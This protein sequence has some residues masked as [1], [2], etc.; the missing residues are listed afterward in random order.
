M[1]PADLQALAASL[2]YAATLGI[3]AAI[4]FCAAAGLIVLLAFMGAHRR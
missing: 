4:A 1:A 2:G 3:V